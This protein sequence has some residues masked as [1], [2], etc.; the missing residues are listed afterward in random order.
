M[1]V[2]KPGVCDFCGIYPAEFTINGGL[3]WL[4]SPCMELEYGKCRCT[5]DL[6]LNHAGDC[7]FAHLLG[8]EEE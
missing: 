3:W 6:I 1:K 8:D 5:D 4:C 2:S 7:K